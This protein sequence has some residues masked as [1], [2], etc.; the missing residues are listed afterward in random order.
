MTTG[1]SQ[2]DLEGAQMLMAGINSNEAFNLN[3]VLFIQHGTVEYPDVVPPNAEETSTSQQASSDWD[4][5]LARDGNRCR[6][7][8]SKPSVSVPDVMTRLVSLSTI[9]LSF[10]NQ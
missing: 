6:D 2:S 9:C 3:E 10:T 8:S 7:Q 1:E 5:W 4:F